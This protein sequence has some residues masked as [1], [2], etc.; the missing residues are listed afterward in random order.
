M[1]FSNAQITGLTVKDEGVSVATPA[2]SLDFVGAGVSATATN[3]RATATIS[4]SAGTSVSEETPTDSGDHLNFTLAHTPIAG[5]LKLYRG[6]ARQQL[7]VGKD[8]TLSGGT[9]TLVVALAT[10]EIL[11]ADYAY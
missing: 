1:S 11:L 8:Y 9:I 10:V 5:S 3:D 6:G 4:G 2:R 7:G